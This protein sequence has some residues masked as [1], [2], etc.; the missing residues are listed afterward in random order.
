[1]DIHNVQREEIENIMVK[2]VLFEFKNKLIS[3]AEGK[4]KSVP[5]HY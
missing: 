5:I 1:M 3:L 2:L 4:K